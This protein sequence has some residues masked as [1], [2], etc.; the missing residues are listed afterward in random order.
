MITAIFSMFKYTNIC[1][2]RKPVGDRIGHLLGLQYLTRSVD[3]GG[4]YVLCY[5]TVRTPS[6][7]VTNEPHFCC[8]YAADIYTQKQFLLLL[9]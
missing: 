2:D 3:V 5:G 4:Y 8:A 6:G 1:A 9:C 7:H